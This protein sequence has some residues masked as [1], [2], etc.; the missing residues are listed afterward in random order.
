MLLGY[1]TKNCHSSF[2]LKSDIHANTLRE[3]PYAVEL[4]FLLLFSA[5]EG[6]TVHYC[7]IEAHETDSRGVSWSLHKPVNW[8]T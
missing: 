6:Y 4:V 3:R 1:F 8:F 5:S 2:W 7:L